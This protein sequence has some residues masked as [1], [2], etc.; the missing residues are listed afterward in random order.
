MP[1]PTPVNDL[2]ARKLLLVRQAQLYREILALERLS[3]SETLDNVRGQLQSRRWWL[4][5]GVA[6]VGWL[7]S[8]RLSGIARWV[9]A[10][11]SAM[12]FAQ[13]LRG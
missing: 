6:C 11:L 13:K 1:A 10:A 12:R 4:I 5:G 2:A 9:P 3:I 8:G 7:L